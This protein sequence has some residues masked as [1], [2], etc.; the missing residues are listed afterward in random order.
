MS[1]RVVGVVVC[2]FL[3]VIVALGAARAQTEVQPS[4][5]SGQSGSV[6]ALADAQL[7]R[8]VVVDAQARRVM[9]YAVSG[10]ELTL[11]GVRNIVADG[12][13]PPKP[14]P[15]VA[16]D[17]PKSDTPGQDLPGVKRPEGGVRVAFS[18]EKEKWEVRYLVSGSFAAVYDRVR[19][20]VAGWDVESETS[21]T[22]SRFSFSPGDASLKL[23]HDGDVLDV[24]I[25]SYRPG[26]FLVSLTLRQKR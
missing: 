21:S 26:Y 10:N 16:E 2:V 7:Q 3:G 11:L 19:N 23:G 13:A 1:Q 5:V 4:P 24:G 25:S 17:V 18:H 12:N 9:L 15:A 20:V 6:I 22:V 14:T 8:I